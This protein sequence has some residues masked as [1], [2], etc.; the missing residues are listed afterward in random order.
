[1]LL[2]L[3]DAFGNTH[4]PEYT[5]NVYKKITD[6][7]VK[8]YQNDFYGAKMIYVQRRTANNGDIE[9]AVN[10]GIYL[11]KKYPEIFAGF[12][13]V[14]QEDTGNPLLYYINELLIPSH[15]GA[16]LPYFFHAGETNWEG[17]TVDYNLADALL[18]KTRRIG[19]GYAFTKHEEF[20]KNAKSMGVAAEVCPISNQV[21]I[22]LLIFYLSID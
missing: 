13:L 21:D 17:Q 3:Y 18:L 7:F 11:K 16:D 1:M 19:H 14:G 8:T 15:T 4:D 6:R 10:E 2:P 9:K 12:D 5:L 20:M 22:L